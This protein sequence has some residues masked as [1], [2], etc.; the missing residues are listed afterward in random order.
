MNTEINYVLSSSRLNTDYRSNIPFGWSCDW[1]YFDGRYRQFPCVDGHII[2]NPTIEGLY[3]VH[4]EIFFVMYEIES[5]IAVIRT[6]TDVTQYYIFNFH[7][8]SLIRFTDTYPTL[9]AFMERAGC[10]TEGG[11]Q[12]NSVTPF[13]L[14]EYNLGPIEVLDL[15]GE[16][17]TGYHAAVMKGREPPL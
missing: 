5:P 2:S 17:N 3:D 9:Q 14:V 10:W 1:E 8:D 12:I 13:E 11:T 15:V 4:G 6:S 16:W 7:T